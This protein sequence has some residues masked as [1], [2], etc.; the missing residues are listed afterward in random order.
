MFRFVAI[1]ALASF[2]AQS[3]GLYSH[4]EPPCK[5]HC[6][7]DDDAGHCSPFCVCTGCGHAV[8]TAVQVRGLKLWVPPMTGWSLEA[9]SLR[10]DAPDPAEIL[11]V[12]KASLAS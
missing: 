5:E 12:P 2:L 6:P 4:F 7:D 9:E 3:S 10:P 8:R 1:L 11:H